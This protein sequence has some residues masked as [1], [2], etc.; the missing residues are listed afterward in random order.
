[1]RKQGN[2]AEMQGREAQA[3]HK[4]AHPKRTAQLQ[5]AWPGQDAGHGGQ[6]AAAT[7]IPVLLTVLRPR[8]TSRIGSGATDGM[9]LLLLRLLV[10]LLVLLLLLKCSQH[11]PLQDLVPLP[12]LLLGC[13]CW[14]AEGRYLAAA[15]P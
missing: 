1:M 13:C 8:T 12:P 9:L 11:L 10:L 14:L 15:S 5:A 7:V 2:G 4:L 6:V 3:L